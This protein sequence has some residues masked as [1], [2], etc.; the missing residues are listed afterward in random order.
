MGA[1]EQPK[2]GIAAYQHVVVLV[3]GTFARGA[4]WT[5]E[6]SPL[7][8]AVAS[9]LHG[10]VLLASFEWSGSNTHAAR[11]AAGDS[12]AEL[13][14]SLRRSHPTASIHVVAHS[15]GGNVLA[16][17]MR[18]PDV[19]GSLENVVCLGTPFIVAQPR[20][21][22]PTLRLL[23]FLEIAVKVVVALLI[24][25][26]VALVV[27]SA[28]YVPGLATF[29][30]GALLL[31]VIGVSS[32]RVLRLMAR[33]S[34]YVGLTLVPGLRRQQVDIVTLLQAQFDNVRIL[35]LQT[36]RDEAAGFLRLVDRVA[37]I[38]FQL[39]SPN[40]VLWATAG[41]T[42]LYV[43]GMVFVTVRSEDWSQAWN[44]AMLGL[45]FA[46]MAYVVLVV[47]TLAVL[48]LVAQVVCTVWPKI[49]RGHALGFGEDGFIKNWLVN[50]SASRR[51]SAAE[52]S[53]DELLSVTGRGLRHSLLYQ[54]E[55]AIE[56]VAEWIGGKQRL[57]KGS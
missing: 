16:Y 40:V 34:Q 29:M 12:L 11:L 39:W 49:F 10:S 5:Q 53:D 27:T 9:A 56:C 18:Q 51:P 52:R 6:D 32:K 46:Y 13:L 36:R 2:S 37:R 23:K 14:S 4:N 30:G 21:L 38:P 25:L 24:A 31:L 26:V 43:V 20:N 45:L 3:H 55:R 17:A 7:A 19:S 8:T 50:I 48:T 44:E 33:L 1:P 35:N 22:G 47:I 54:D 28:V 57:V 15:H 41:I 42:V